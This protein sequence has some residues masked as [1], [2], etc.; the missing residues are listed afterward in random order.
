MPVYYLLIG[1]TTVTQD[2]VDNYQF[3]LPAQIA[4]AMYAKFAPVD[5]GPFTLW[6]ATPDTTGGI[7][8]QYTV[9][10]CRGSGPMRFSWS[11]T[12]TKDLLDLEKCKVGPM[13]KKN[14]S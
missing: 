14:D 7:P 6:T 9:R 1:A 5:V 4:K 11:L 8:N 10:P 2:S 13:A 12:P 3:L